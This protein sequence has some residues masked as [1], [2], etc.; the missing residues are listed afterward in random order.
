M[1]DVSAEPS[2]SEEEVWKTHILK[3]RASRL[4][5]VKYCQKN[6]L[7]VWRFTTFKEAGPDETQISGQ[8]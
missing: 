4:S 1:S 6:E 5:D 8:A 2:L 7:S 3:A